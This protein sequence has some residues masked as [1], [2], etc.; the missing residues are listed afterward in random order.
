VPAAGHRVGPLDHLR[1][2][3]PPQAHPADRPAG[4]EPRRRE[5]TDPQARQDHVLYQV[6]AVRA[7]GDPR[8]E[9]GQ[10]GHHPDHLLVGG[11]ARVDDP[12]VVPVAAEDLHRGAA[13][14]RAGRRAQAPRGGAQRPAVQLLAVRPGIQPGRREV[15]VI[16]QHEVHLVRR[17]QGQRLGRFLLEQVQP[18]LRL[19][20]GQRPGD[21][22]QDLAERRGEGGHPHRPGR[23][24]R[25]VQ[26]AAGGLDRGQDGDRVPGQPPPGRG[27]PHPPPVRLGQR[28]ARLP[29]QR[30]DLLRHGG[31]GDV[32]RLA[33]LAH[34]AEAGQ[35]EQ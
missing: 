18:D 29:G 35:L 1:L 22:Q 12:G 17:E 5:Q 25:R 33:D 7:L 14:T 28:G 2:S 30:R 32:H 11:V 26:V 9:A 31:G 10:R 34:R 16:G 15:V 27:Q 24:S 3:Q 4:R 23:R 13:G 8:L 6:E 19:P 21:R 20:S